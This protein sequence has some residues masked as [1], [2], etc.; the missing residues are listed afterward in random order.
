MVEVAAV[1]ATVG[2]N[3]ADIAAATPSS[4][5]ALYSN[6]NMRFQ[7]FFMLMTVQPFLLASS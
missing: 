2:T 7:S 5:S 6:A 3:Y 1:K 4:T